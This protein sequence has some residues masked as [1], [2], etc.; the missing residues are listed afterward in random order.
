MSNE[1]KI[2]GVCGSFHIPEVP[3]NHPFV[4]VSSAEEGN[5]NCT[6]GRREGAVCHTHEGHSDYHPYSPKMTRVS[7]PQPNECPKCGNLHPGLKHCQECGGMGHFGVELAFEDCKLCDG[8]GKV[9]DVPQSKDVCPKCGSL[10]IVIF[11]DTP[12]KCGKCG[13]CLM[14]LPDSML[15]Q[16]SHAEAVEDKYLCADSVHRDIFQRGVIQGR[17]SL[18]VEVDEARKLLSFFHGRKGPDGNDESEMEEWNEWHDR[19][20]RW[21]EALAQYQKAVKG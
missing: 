2:C 12:F 1:D 20:M 16:V 3:Y 7:A 10:D 15:P 17:A 8:T 21:L 6:C 9:A 14:D 19:Y 11:S 18:Q 13:Y 4:P 5:Y